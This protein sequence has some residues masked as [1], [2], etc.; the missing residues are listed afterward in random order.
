M[1]RFL[2]ITLAIVAV[3]IV[4]A[5]LTV[6]GEQGD[7]LREFFS[8][9]TWRRGSEFIAK[10]FGAGVEQ[11]AFTD[12]QRW[13]EAARLAY[14][15]LR[16]SV[17]AIGMAGIGTLL[18]VIPGARNA[19]DGSLTLTRSPFSRLV[20][21][22]VR[23]LFTFSRAVPELV[24]TMLIIFVFS[25]GILPGAIA[26]GLHNF[27]ILGKLCAEVVENVDMRPARALRN[28]GAGTMQTL[29]YGVM[30]LVMP[31]CLSYLLYRW[32]IIIRTTIVVGFVSAGGLGREFRLAMSWL[33]YDEV[34]L[35][36]MCY[37]VLVLM[38]DMMSGLLRRLARE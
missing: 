2:R 28:A 27:G 31:Q 25:P 8:L 35:I 18:L 22:L 32:E 33:H 16:M 9:A 38:V 21:W 3:M 20:Y 1:N 13:V 26:L 19:A 30:P 24:W 6:F 15:T 10:F 5:W 11:P 34:A 4:L 7:R 14:E 12:P 23:F 17:L 37:L 29:L 36:L